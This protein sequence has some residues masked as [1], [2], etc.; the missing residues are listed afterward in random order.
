MQLVLQIIR[1][2]C[3][4]IGKDRWRV[5][6][7][8]GGSVGRAPNSHW[9][10][11]DPNCYVSGHHCDVEFRDGSFW[12]RDASRNGVFLNNAHYPV[13]FGR[14]VELHDGDRLA[15]AGYGV[16]VRIHARNNKPHGL[17]GVELASRPEPDDHETM[18]AEGAETTDEHAAIANHDESSFTA[19]RTIDGI[20]VAN[21]S[22]RIVEFDRT[23]LRAAGLLPP[24]QQERLI[25]NQFRQIKRPIIANALGR[26]VPAVQNG[27]IVMVT[28]AF[29]GE[30]K[31]FSAVNLALS[32]SREKELDVLL[33]DADVA[34]PQIS[35]LLGINREPGLLEALMDETID[36]ES[37]ILRSDLKGLSIVPAGLFA[38]DVATELL[39]SSRMEE[40]VTRIAAENP[41]RMV[42]LDSPPLLLTNESRVLAAAVGQIVLVVRAGVT[43]QQA[44][45]EAI[46][47]LDE[48]KPIGLVLNQ[49]KAAGPNSYYGYGS[50]GYG[51]YGNAREDG[52]SA[53]TQAQENG[54]PQTQKP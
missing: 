19:T 43:P 6:G 13:G 20:T 21:R 4:D 37:L 44:V 14:D 36:V 52:H 25:A 33:I 31:T 46:A 30:G 26:H 29:P 32:I 50:Y 35:S 10:L 11:P 2:P 3:V 24:E 8:S 27:R 53:K 51:G 5:F 54:S 15:I 7:E 49:S 39:A 1:D 18:I 12:L 17:H 34:K 41:R 47:Y 40:I 45:L 23:K 9:V 42:V 22:S 16:R 28:S 38:E 48:Q